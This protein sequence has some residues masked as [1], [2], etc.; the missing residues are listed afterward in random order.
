MTKKESEYVAS[1]KELDTVFLAWRKDTKCVKCGKPI[2]E[3]VSKS[4]KN[5][6][7]LPDFWESYWDWCF[8]CLQVEAL[9]PSE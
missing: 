6:P 5:S 4:F 8:T 1:L 3:I 7:Y 2:K 9:L